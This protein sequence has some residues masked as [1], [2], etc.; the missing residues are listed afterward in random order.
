MDFLKRLESLEDADTAD[1]LVY[2]RE[3]NEPIGIFVMAGPNHTA[4]KEF[5]RKEAQRVQAAAARARDPMKALNK[6]TVQALDPDASEEFA[7][8]HLCA[9]TVGWKNADGSAAS[10]PFDAKK[11]EAFYRAKAWLRDDAAKFLASDDAFTTS[12]QSK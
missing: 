10:E 5:R 6:E 2:D 1:W 4:T 8:K 3:T 12:S 9:R 7:I 11:V